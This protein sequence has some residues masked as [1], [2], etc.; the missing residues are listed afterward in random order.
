MAIPFY[1]R[2]APRCA[3]CQTRKPAAQYAK[4]YEGR[5]WVA[6]PICVACE[7]SVRPE[8]PTYEEQ[9]KESA[10]L[11]AQ[12]PRAEKSKLVPV[13][14]CPGCNRLLKL[15]LFRK[16]WGVK[17][18]HRTLCIECEPERRLEN[19]TQAQR[20]ALA[21]LGKPRVTPERLARLSA[22]EADAERRRRSLAGK[23]RHSAERTRAWAPTLR[24]LS[25]ERAW[26]LMHLDRSP[27]PEWENFFNAYA[28]ALRDALTRAKTKKLQTSSTSAAPPPEA[29]LTWET[30]LALGRLYASCQ[31]IPG[32]RSYRVPA[33]IDW[34]NEARLLG[35]MNEDKVSSLK[36]EK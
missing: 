20:E 27:T 19:M 30:L 31:I 32:R 25:A 33:C 6:H 7:P 3:R 34:L 36:G 14:T 21:S 23:R 4:W 18:I 15:Q 28:T 10:Y 24:T 29:F 5:F 17:R 13:A 9:E 2:A 22:E 1:D 8:N 26:C 35:V 11:Q 12:I 16:W